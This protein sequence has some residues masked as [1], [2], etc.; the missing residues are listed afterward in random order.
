[1][2]TTRNIYVGMGGWDLHP[3]DG[4]FYP[5]KKAR[6]FRKLEF[7]SHHFDFVEINSTFY[8]SEFKPVQVNRW[9]RDV[10]DN[11]QF[12][13]TVKLFRGFTHSYDATPQDVVNVRSLLDLLAAG[14]KLGG[15]LMQFP[16][17]F[18][19]L[20]ERRLYLVRLCRAFQPHTLFVEVRHNS[21]NVPLVQK[22]FREHGISAVNVDLPL[23]KRH[24]PMTQ[25]ASRSHAYFRMMGR[26]I[27]TWDNPWR[28]EKTGTHMVSDR[29]NYYYSMEELSHLSRVI[30]VLQP[31]PAKTF[32]VF[33][34]DPNAHSLLNGFQLRKILQP[35][36][37]IVAPETL[38]RAFP[39]LAAHGIDREEG[40]SLFRL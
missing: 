13:F 37:K 40:L 26:N 23:I 3:F 4:V 20:H 14:N 5:S 36:Q 30:E 7:Y 21:W 12:I 24:I 35:K 22:M 8:S 6:G 1:M 25:I 38:M 15:L 10:G 29:Y 11:E 9:L 28:I 18:T 33:H 17:S 34:N 27:D 2:P 19:N 16:Y 32:I 31:R 39:L